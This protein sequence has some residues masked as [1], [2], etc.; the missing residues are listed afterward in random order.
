MSLAARLRPAPPPPSAEEREREAVH[1]LAAVRGRAA[2]APA[3]TTNRSLSALLRGLKP[4]DARAGGLSLRDLQ[5]RW[6]DIAGAPFAGKTEPEKLAAGVLTVSAPRALAP[7]VQ[8]QS[9]LLMERLAVAGLKLKGVRIVHRSAQAKPTRAAG[10]LAK[11]APE[12]AAVLDAD[13]AK[14]L[15]DVADPKLR[16][17]LLELGRSVSKR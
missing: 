6:G 11:L 13:L 5:R 14:A 8:Q 2:I 10:N 15:K 4:D 3:P 7:L 16:A 17:A 1:T 9:G 12:D